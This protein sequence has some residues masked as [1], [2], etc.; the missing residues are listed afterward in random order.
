[1][2]VRVV[3]IG[4]S[5]KMIRAGADC[6]FLGLL[7]LLAFCCLLPVSA[8]GETIGVISPADVSY[9]NELHSAFMAA[10]NRSSD[11]AKVIVQRPFPD[12]ISLSNAARKLIALDVDVIVVYGAPALFAVE[13]ERT[14]IPVVYA[15]VYEQALR[16]ARARNVTG[17]SSRILVSSVLRYLR[18]FTTPSSIGVVFSSTEEDSVLQMK[19]VLKLSSYY[20]ITPTA[21]DI[22]RPRDA[23][24]ALAAAKVDA[25]F[26]TGSSIGSLASPAIMQFARERKIP[27][28]SLMPDRNSQPV[29]SLYASPKEQGEK[30]AAITS[31]I[32]QGVSPETI[33]ADSADHIELIF[34]MRQAKAMGLRIPMDLVTEA[35]RLIQ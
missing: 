6:L 24:G 22:K 16:K 9:Y 29:V 23:G 33:K 20:G 17:V 10:L 25:I 4:R 2:V 18:S 31:K 30:A 15:G 14:R 1:M 3:A 5:G 28:A 34:D 8:S 11:N 7:S 26:I 27:T 21:I 13:G 35:T 19:E 12:P 32:L